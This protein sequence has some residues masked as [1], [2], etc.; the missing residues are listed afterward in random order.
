MKI[1][2]PKEC[3]HLDAGDASG[4]M[5]GYSHNLEEIEISPSQPLQKTSILSFSSCSA[6]KDTTARNLSRKEYL[7]SS[8]TPCYEGLIGYGA[9]FRDKIPDI[10]RNIS[11][12]STHAAQ[13]FWSLSDLRTM[14]QPRANDPEFLAILRGEDAETNAPTT[15]NQCR[16]QLNELISILDQIPNLSV[17]M[18][19]SLQKDVQAIQAALKPLE[20]GTPALGRAIKGCVNLINL[21]PILVPS[22][23]LANQAKTFA[24]TVAAAAKAVLSV[25]GSTLRSTADGLPFPLMPGELG[26]QANE[27][28]FYPALLNVIF[29]SSELAKRFGSVQSRSTAERIV[30]NRAFHAAVS[31]CC[32]MALITPF[33]WDSLKYRFQQSVNAIKLQ[34]ARSLE[35]MGFQNVS[36]TLL[37]QLR[38]VE[39][40]GQMR[41]ALQEIWMQL[42]DQCKLIQKMRLDFTESSTQRELTRTL[43]SQCTHLLEKISQCSRNLAEKFSL[44]QSPGSPADEAQINSTLSSKFALMLLA[45]SVTGTCVFLI[46][47]DRIGTADLSADAVVVTSVMAQSVLNKQATQ[48]DT[49]ERFKS[50][51]STSIVMSLALSIDKL[52]KF[53]TSK[54][55]IESSPDSAYYASM[56]MTLMA[57]TLPGPIARGAELIINQA[58]RSIGSIMNS[59][60]S[61][62][63]RTHKPETISELSLHLQSV[64]TYI[65]QL[66]HEERQAY[67][68]YVRD[69]LSRNHAE[70][71]EVT[72]ASSQTDTPT[73]V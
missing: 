8:I 61:N 68:A 13:T 12:K 62:A 47:P 37:G 17:S 54:G 44:Q 55:L 38:P 52:S 65:Q 14:L 57:M 49:M 25:F 53:V 64:S 3:Y 58:G 5:S 41:K 35:K 56:I 63:L 22:P 32:G 28:H 67:E 66:D 18:R 40:D 7:L 24:Y 60:N 1:I 71:F 72:V 29:L 26:R 69:N 9:S 16:R 23:L 59:C 50:M 11:G 19:N 15:F 10:F 33:V 20:Q 70:P 51:A 30:E 31:I 42:E 34:G 45:A 43:N 21:W 36:H 39:V 6:D 2:N 48:Q 73:F 4:E 46:Q 27:V